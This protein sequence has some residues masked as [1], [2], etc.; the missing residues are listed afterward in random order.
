MTS[1]K[2]HL[3]GT[4]LVAPTG[5][6]NSLSLQTVG[7]ISASALSTAPIAVSPVTALIDIEEL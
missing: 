6:D 3:H 2:T 5:A 7:Y 1:L 4:L